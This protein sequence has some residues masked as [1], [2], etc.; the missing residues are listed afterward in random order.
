MLQR[1]LRFRDSK[2]FYGPRLR[3]HLIA[4]N[5]SVDIVKKRTTNSLVGMPKSHLNPV[6]SGLQHPAAQIFDFDRSQLVWTTTAGGNGHW[7]VIAA[8]SLPSPTHDVTR[9]SRL[10]CTSDV[11]DTSDDNKKEFRYLEIRIAAAK[12]VSMAQTFEEQGF[13]NR[14]LRDSCLEEPTMGGKTSDWKEE[15]GRFLA[16]FVA[17]LGHNAATDVSSDLA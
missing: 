8:A 13:P 16:P 7:R 11:I 14:L 12:V 1:S 15:L 4:R 3:G 5:R 6:R 2:S 10:G 17:R 9:S